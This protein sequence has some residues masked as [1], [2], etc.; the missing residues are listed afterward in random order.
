MNESRSP[1]FGGVMSQSTSQLIRGLE[2]CSNRRSNQSC[3]GANDCNSTCKQPHG[4]H[5]VR[6]FLHLA[7]TR[8][9]RRNRQ[10]IWPPRR[11]PSH[12]PALAC[13]GRDPHCLGHPERVAAAA[14]RK[15]PATHEQSEALRQCFDLAPARLAEFLQV[16]AVPVRGGLNFVRSEVWLEIYLK[17]GRDHSF[18]A[19]DH[20]GRGG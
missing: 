3:S 12:R 16:I 5:R 2:H 9:L 11:G 1:S 20:R 14:A 17:D 6:S 7:D 13:L 15:L 8:G 18:P 4:G 10:S 19:L